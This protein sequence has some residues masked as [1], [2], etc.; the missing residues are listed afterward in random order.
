MIHIFALRL[1]ICERATFGFDANS[2][3]ALTGHILQRGFLGL[4]IEDARSI[5]A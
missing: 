2:H 5:N 3:M 4:Q 1:S